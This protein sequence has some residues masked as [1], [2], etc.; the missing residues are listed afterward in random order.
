M[1]HLV[2][3]FACAAV[4]AGCLAPDG[5][6]ARTLDRDGDG[7]QTVRVG[8][9][10]CDDNDP[11][12]GRQQ[13]ERC[14]NGLDDDCDGL[15]DEDGIGA[16]RVFRDGDGDGFGDPATGRDACA[17]EP[18]EVVDGS[19]CDDGTRDVAP[20]Q[21]E[22]CNGV[23]DDCDGLIDESGE[24]VSWFPDG[25]GDGFGRT[26][27]EVVTCAPPVG[28]VPRGGDCHDADPA[29]SPGADDLPYDGVDADCAGDD[30][31]DGDGDGV[32]G[33]GAGPDCDD[34]APRVFPGAVEIY[35]DGIDQDCDPRNDDDR[36]GDGFDGQA[37]GGPDCDDTNPLIHPGAL[38]VPYDGVDADCA[39]DDDFDADGDGLRGDGGPDCD[40]TDPTVGLPQTWWFDGDGDGWGQT[41]AGTTRCTRPAG[42]WVQRTG[43]C[44]DDTARAFPGGS[45][46]SAGCDGIDNDCD[47]LI[48][49]GLGTL[50]YPDLDDDGQGDP[51]GAVGPACTA[52]PGRW[53]ANALDCDDS[54]PHTYR[55]APL[56][57]GGGDEDCDPAT[58]DAP[59][60]CD[61]D[62]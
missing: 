23:D 40:D 1:R 24:P 9:T 58:P 51:E 44:R 19:D 56:R 5:L 27:G 42:R 48:D 4:T 16:V 18:D 15:L 31:F 30:D 59:P 46:A 22:V 54:D 26:S 39:G 8:G 6:V 45:E 28:Y 29:V 32:R 35:Y 37:V 55:G 33:G 60:T 11:T 41:G 43:D 2:A 49:E 50:W 34:T 47:G 7:E 13:P 10:D 12:I 61:S 14:G 3:C 17:P 20:G 62:A 38:D 52:P 53:A 25:D 36:D 21:R 57:C